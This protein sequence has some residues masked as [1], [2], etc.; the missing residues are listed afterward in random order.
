MSTFKARLF[1]LALHP[2]YC[3]P[4]YREHGPALDERSER[5]ARHDHRVNGAVKSLKRS[6]GF[7]VSVTLMILVFSSPSTV[8]AAEGGPQWTVTSVSQPTNFRPEDTTGEDSYQVVVTNTGGAASNGEPVTITDELPAGLSLAPAGASGV[9]QLVV[10]VTHKQDGGEFTCVRRTCTFTGTVVPEEMLIV[11]FPVEVTAGGQQSVTN[12][13]HVSG[14][15]AP[16]ASIATSTD[17][18]DCRSR[19]RHLAGQRDERAIQQ[20]GWRP[21]GYH[22]VDRVQHCRHRGQPLARRRTRRNPGSGAVRLRRRPG[23]HAYVSGGGVL[24]PG[25]SVAT[26]VGV[27]TLTLLDHNGEKELRTQAVYNLSPESRR[28]GEVRIQRRR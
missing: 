27:T 3:L 11:T 14:G 26:Q 18:S 1:R 2:A 17:I 13:A 23:R 25:M 16:D 7:A 6:I 12:V 22:H 20:P 28:S 9:D 21:P 5:F 19:I 24:A 8:L 15:G 4:P 10:A